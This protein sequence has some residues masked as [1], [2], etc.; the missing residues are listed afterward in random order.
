LDAS[1]RASAPHTIARPLSARTTLV[2]AEPKVVTDASMRWL[3]ARMGQ[4]PGVHVDADRGRGR[5]TVRGEWWFLATY[6]FRSVD[7]G[8]VVSYRCDNIARTQRW[9]VRAILLQYR[10]N[11][12]LARIRDGDMTELL[13]HLHAELHCRTHDLATEPHD[14]DDP[15]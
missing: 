3:S 13:D 9:T 11:G 4:Q 10:F 12:I 5:F 2:E 15:S 6:T 8:T 7:E 14:A 1:H